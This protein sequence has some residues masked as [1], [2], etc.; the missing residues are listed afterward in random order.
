MLCGESSPEALLVVERSLLEQ[1]HVLGKVNA[2]ELTVPLCHSSCAIH[3]D[4]D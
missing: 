4:A 2:P 1:H 3:T